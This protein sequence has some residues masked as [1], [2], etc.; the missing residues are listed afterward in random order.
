MVSHNFH[1]RPLNSKLPNKFPC[2]E[3]QHV[4]DYTGVHKIAE[5]TNTCKGTNSAVGRIGYDFF[6]HS[7]TYRD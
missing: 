3:R 5:E 4:W 7:S 2:R 6:N 1:I